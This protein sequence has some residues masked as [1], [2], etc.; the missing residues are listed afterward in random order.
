MRLSSRKNLMQPKITGID[1]FF[2]WAF[3]NNRSFQKMQNPNPLFWWIFLICANMMILIGF[4]S[5]RIT[6]EVHIF[7]CGCLLLMV[8]KLSF[9]LTDLGYDGL[10][11]TTTN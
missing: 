1:P 6:A 11:S 7:P 8:S 2:Y 3:F 4:L 10:N 9:I 5:S